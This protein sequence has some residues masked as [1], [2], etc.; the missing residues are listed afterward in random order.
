MGFEAMLVK[1]IRWNRMIIG[2]DQ[3]AAFKDELNYILIELKIR[4]TLL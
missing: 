4:I 3:F 1:I 2:P